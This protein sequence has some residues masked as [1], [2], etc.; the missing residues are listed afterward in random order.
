VNP[1][2]EP[3]NVVS[4]N[5][6]LPEARYPDSAALAVFY[7][8]AIDTLASQPGV[9]AA[10]AVMRPP[11]SRG[12]FGGTF[13]IIGREDNDDRRLQVR[14]ATPGYF[15]AVRIPLRRGRLFTNADS[16]QSAHVAILSDEAARRYWPGEDPMGKRIRIHVSLGER[17]GEREIVGVVGDVKIRTLEAAPVPVVYVP[18]AQYASDE[19]TVFVRAAGDPVALLPAIR[20]QVA[21]IDRELALTNVQTADRLVAASVA[22]PRFRML[23]LGVFAVMAL[24]LAAVG[25]YGV[26]AYSVSQRRGELGLRMALGAESGHVLRLVLREGLL[27]VASGIVAGLVGAALLTGVMSNLLFEVSAFDPLTFGSVSALL[28]LVA[29][30]ACYLPAR[31]ATMVDP[32]TALRNEP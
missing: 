17:E 3:S 24:T 11:L 31:R 5:V 14:P 27:P 7:R 10:G 4:L 30:A 8:T 29:A 1:G 23:M 20:S 18:H 26:M 22:Q 16:T 19:M 25:L 15:E 13:S 2:F 21:L 9:V 6:A 28:A 12:G 32:L